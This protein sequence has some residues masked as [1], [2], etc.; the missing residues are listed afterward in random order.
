MKYA[1][2]E[3]NGQLSTLLYAKD[4][5]A[6][7]KDAGIQ[8]KETELPVTLISAGKLLEK[9]LPVAKRDRQWLDAELKKRNCTIRGALLLTVDAAGKIYLVRKEDVR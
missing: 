6:N 3:T 1:I 9:N 5:P 4:R 7:A 8:A 2:L